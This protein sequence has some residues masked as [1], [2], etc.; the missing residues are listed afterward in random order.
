M[1][2]IPTL[3][4][5]NPENMKL[6]T[7]EVN[8]DAA[9]VFDSHG[10]PTIKR[11]GTNVRV[12]VHNGKCILL[13]K[14]RNPTREEKAQGI[15]P[16]YVNADTGNP[17]DKHIFAAMDATDFTSWPNG[18]HPCEA[19]G[20]K[21]QG[22]IES[23]YPLLYPFLLRPQVVLDFPSVVT[24]DSIRD[25]LASHP[26]EGIVWHDRMS[27]GMLTPRMAKIKRRDFDLPWPVRVKS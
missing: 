9:W 27:Q 13:E 22:G 16:D 26:Y 20:P 10:V 2:K 24:F 8:P 15:E 5:R 21:I 25:Y 4:L 7:R 6:V 18:K 17:S 11:D 23:P 1:N 12:T 14:R 19:L 3:F